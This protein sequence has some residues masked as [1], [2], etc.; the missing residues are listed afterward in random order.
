MYLLDTNICIFL[1]NGKSGYERI[2]AKMDGLQR[3]TVM[4]S[5]ISAAE[6]QYGV[7]ASQRRNDNLLRLERFLAEFEVLA[8]DERAARTYG[9]AR[10]TLRESGTPIGPLDTLIAGHALAIGATLITNNLREFR[11]VPGLIA[12]DWSSG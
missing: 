11:R 2:V 12:E 10:A 9:Q 5:S 6:L 7:W 4:V 8:F 3:G 1:L